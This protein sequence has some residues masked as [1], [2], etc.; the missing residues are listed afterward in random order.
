MTD[1]LDAGSTSTREGVPGADIIRA[2]RALLVWAVLASLVYTALSH[3][4]QGICPG[5]FDGSGAFI[6]AD[7][8][9]TDTAPNC[10]TVSLL[11]SPFVYGIIGG[12]VIA[13]LS[14]ILR[15][16]SSQAEAL[17]FISRA[18]WIVCGV[19][20]ASILVAQI[21]FAQLDLSSWNGGPIQVLFPFPF[22]SGSVEIT[23]LQ[24]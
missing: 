11:P 19:A 9:P 13:V 6:D 12:S 15:R 23:P 18:R 2:I 8:M 10:L 21:W 3:A 4:T 24:G 14:I 16:A 17:R 1:T 7:G 20:L 22:S 5:G